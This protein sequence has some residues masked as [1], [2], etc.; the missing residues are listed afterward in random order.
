[1]MSTRRWVLARCAVQSCG[2]GE[3]YLS[4]A[5]PRA[6]LPCKGRFSP[7]GC[8]AVRRSPNSSCCGGRHPRHAAAVA[9][10]VV[11]AVGF[12]STG[13]TTSRPSPICSLRPCG[14]P[15][16]SLSKK[17]ATGLLTVEH[18]HSAVV[19]LLLFQVIV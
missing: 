10:L 6:V 4:E 1:M 15:S 13:T 9:K 18:S 8:G 3:Q 17:S 2:C 5:H 7:A 12:G 19:L 14:I 16:S 11:P